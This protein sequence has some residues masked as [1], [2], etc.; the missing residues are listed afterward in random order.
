MSKDKDF[1]VSKY[2]GLQNQNFYWERKKFH[3]NFGG[4]VGWLAVRIYNLMLDYFMLKS[5]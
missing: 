4:L 1:A 2:E 3:F 5:I